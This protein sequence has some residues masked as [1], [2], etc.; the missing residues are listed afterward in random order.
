LNFNSDGTFSFDP[1]NAY[2]YLGVGESTTLSFQFAASDGQGSDSTATE[3]ITINGLND[4]PTAAP[5][6]LCSFFQAETKRTFLPTVGIEIY[7]ASS[8]A[9]TSAK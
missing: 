7:D 9:G 2:K 5:D 1:G 4:N 6:L 3:T 8:K